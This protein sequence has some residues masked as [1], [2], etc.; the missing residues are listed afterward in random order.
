MNR[1]K[2]LTHEY[3]HLVQTELAGDRLVGPRW[4]IEGSADFFG[5]HAIVFPQMEQIVVSNKND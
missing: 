2:I 3:F 1:V 5:H 4:L